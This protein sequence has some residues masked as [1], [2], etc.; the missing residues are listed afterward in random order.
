MDM[1]T[2]NIPLEAKVAEIYNAASTEEQ[3]KLHVLVSLWLREM[4]DSDESLTTIMDR[5]S[6]R[7]AARGLTP[8][9]LES[10][11]NDDAE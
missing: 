8:E 2:I 3:Q 1:T 4:S 10:L 6:E 9:I 5:I 7:A 11:L